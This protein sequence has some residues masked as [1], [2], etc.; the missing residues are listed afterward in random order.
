MGGKVRR[1]AAFDPAE[2]L[3][4]IRKAARLKDRAAFLCQVNEFT[5]TFK[6]SALH[7]DSNPDAEEESQ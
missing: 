6:D 5:A 1:C 2:F 7:R 4:V 3:V